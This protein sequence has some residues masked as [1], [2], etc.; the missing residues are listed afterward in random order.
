VALPQFQNKKNGG[1]VES[2][3]YT[4]GFFSSRKRWNCRHGRGCRRKI[5][6]TGITSSGFGKSANGF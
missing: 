5:V 4:Q 2:G 6:C 3:E 1:T